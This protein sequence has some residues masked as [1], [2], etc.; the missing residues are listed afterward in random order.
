[1]FL[2]GF[3]VQK[4]QL[5]LALCSSNQPHFDSPQLRQVKHPSII[6]AALVLHLLQSCAFLGKPS[7]LVGSAL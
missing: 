7:S 2:N 5:S 4:S 3:S 6:I 1:M